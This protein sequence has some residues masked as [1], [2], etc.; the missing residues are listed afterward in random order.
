MQSVRC[1]KSWIFFFKGFTGIR[2]LRHTL[3]VSPL[4]V[5]DIPHVNERKTTGC[6]LLRARN[7]DT[8]KLKYFIAQS[9]TCVSGFN[10]KSIRNFRSTMGGCTS[11]DTATGDE[12]V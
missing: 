3:L 10:L 1:N 6:S 11:K 8:I 5:Y 12:Y 2:D 7:L 4:P 9:K